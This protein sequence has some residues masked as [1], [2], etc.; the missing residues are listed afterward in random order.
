MPA[1]KTGHTQRRRAKMHQ[2]YLPSC[3][4]DTHVLKN[5][6]KVGDEFRI[7]LCTVFTIGTMSNRAGC[8]LVGDRKEELN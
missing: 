5:N 3:C 4:R 1:S 8:D 7:G 6:L 2:E